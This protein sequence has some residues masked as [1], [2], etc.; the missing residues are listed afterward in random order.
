M[1]R[2][3]LIWLLVFMLI[4][5]LATFAISFYVQTEQAEENGHSLIQLRIEDVKQQL[6]INMR[7]LEE[8]RTESDM[9]ALA[10]VWA[11]AKMVELNPDIIFF[12]EV[13]E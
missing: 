3:F 7:N 5:F 12:G 10:K 2:T 4:G 13:L 6:D 8:I 9:N 1:R 11:L